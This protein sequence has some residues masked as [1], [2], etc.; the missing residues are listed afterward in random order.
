M[1]FGEEAARRLAEVENRDELLAELRV[2]L[3]RDAAGCIAR[4]RRS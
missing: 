3:E 4:R 1:R 2:K